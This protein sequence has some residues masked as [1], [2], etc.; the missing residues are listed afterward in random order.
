MHLNPRNRHLSVEIIDQE[1]EESPFFSPDDCKPKILLPDDYKPIKEEY[2]LV[3]L[4]DCAPDCNGDYSNDGIL[5]VKQNM[6]E[7]IK[8][9]GKTFHLVLENY[10]MGILDE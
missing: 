4:V 7:E 5:V 8:A 10:V 6:I 2:A 3:R 1:E 9:G